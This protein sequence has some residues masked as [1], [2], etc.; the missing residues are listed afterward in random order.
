MSLQVPPLSPQAPDPYLTT[1]PSI[2]YNQAVQGLPL[3][4]PMPYDT[5]GAPLQTPRPQS[6]DAFLPENHAFPASVANQP[7]RR[8]VSK[9]RLDVLERRWFPKTLFTQGAAP[10]DQIANPLKFAAFVGLS[11]LAFR[12]LRLFFSI[13]AAIVAYI[14]QDQ[15]NKDAIS[16]LGSS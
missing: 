13:P 7:G 8:P 1:R 4:G 9:Q 5:T 15:R 16:K 2:Q 14:W 10:E 11:A 3:Q 12:F 6:P